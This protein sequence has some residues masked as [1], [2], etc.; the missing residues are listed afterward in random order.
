[1]F[2]A[3][4]IGPPDRVLLA[5]PLGWAIGSDAY[6]AL[7]DREVLTLACAGSLEDV[8]DFAPTVVIASV[9]DAL[10]LTYAGALQ[11]IDLSESAVRL[12]VVTGEP[13][14]SLPVTRRAIEGHWGAA[15]LDVYA[16]TELGVIGQGCSAR[17]DSLHLNEAHLRL[18]VLHPDSD[19]P[20]PSGQIGELVATTPA[21]WGTPLTNF[22]TG[23]LVRLSTSA[24][25]CGGER[26]AEG[27][28]LGRVG[29]RLL[30]RGTVLL[31]STIEQVVR[32]HPAVVDFQLR[33]YLVRGDCEV[34]VETNRAIASE[35]DRAR[36]A[37]EVSEDLRR[38]LGLLLHCDV[39]PPGSA[40]SNQDSGRRARRL[41]RQ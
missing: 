26:W 2:Q 40:A 41:S 31:P 17:G 3:N 18:Q 36:V 29:E 4:A 9:S 27:G 30:V 14:G 19:A 34:L 7:L 12:V 39:L 33:S 28:V 24:C 21:D 37:A 35:G 15:C 32:R 13:G 23:D 20:V 16:A 11:G 22:R 1:V 8:L 25:A 10:G 6:L 38:S 5:L